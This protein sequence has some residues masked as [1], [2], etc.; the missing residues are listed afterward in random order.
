MGLIQSL[1]AAARRRDFNLG[2]VNGVLFAGVD[3]LLDPRLVLVTFASFLTDSHILLG[4]VYPLSQ[5]GW[6]LP[7]LWVSG[8]FQSRPKALPIYR[9]MAVIRMICLILLALTAYAVKDKGWQL[10]LFFS[11]LMANQLALSLIHI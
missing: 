1:A 5:A 2:V 8:W 9:A 7:Q 11:L 10:L 4:L 6:F 3:T